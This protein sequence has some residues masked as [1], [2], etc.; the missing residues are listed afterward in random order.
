MGSNP[1][2]NPAN[3]EL[4]PMQV[5]ANGVDLGA[6]LKGVKVGIKT[7][8]S[9]IMADQFGKSVLDRRVS[10]HALTVETELA[11]VLNKDIWKR[12]FA[13][14]KKVGTGPYAMYFASA[15]GSSDL[16]NAVQL[17]LHPLSK[18][19]ND[20]SE[21]LTFY[22]ASPDENSDPAWN[23]DNQTA[24]KIVWNVYLD[25]SVQPARL[26]FFGDTTIGLVAASAAAAVAGGGNT[27]NG[28]VTGVTAFSGFTKTETITMTCVTTAVNGGK[29]YVTGSLSGALGM[30]TVGTPFVHPVVAFTINDGATDFA[31]NDSFTIATTAANYA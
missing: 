6:T 15:I 3:M 4:S 26:M 20:K 16:A 24:L 29:F 14:Q 1:N 8:K 7:M 31:V 25:T 27:G 2:V 12:V 18:A 13:S 28:T 21:D 19:A 10:G 17:T 9:N 22:V 5:F 30:A 23:A 11:E